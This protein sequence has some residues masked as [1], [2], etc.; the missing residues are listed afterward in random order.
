MS[1]QRTVAWCV[2]SAGVGQWMVY[3]SHTNSNPVCNLRI[4]SHYLGGS[5]LTSFFDK[6]AFSF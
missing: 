2:I 4:G 3:N 1:Q 6:G 5:T